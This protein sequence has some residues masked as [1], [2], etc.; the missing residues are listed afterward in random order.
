MKSTNGPETQATK[1][2]RQHKVQ[3]F[4]HLYAYEEHSGT[5]VS[6]RELDVDEHALVKTLVMEDESFDCC[7]MAHTGWF[8]DANGCDAKN[9]IC[10]RARS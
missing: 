1:S 4:D 3:F 9:Q 7:E 10:V 6:A 8:R 5:A 2:L